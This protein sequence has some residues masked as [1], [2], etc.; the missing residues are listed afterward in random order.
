MQQASESASDKELSQQ[1]EAM[2]KGEITA[3]LFNKVLIR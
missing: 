2:L 1:P 3:D